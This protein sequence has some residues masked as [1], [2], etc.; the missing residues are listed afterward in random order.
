MKRSILLFLVLLCGSA[1]GQSLFESALTE[2]E[3]ST[4]LPVEINGFIRGMTYAGQ[5]TEKQE[6]DLKAALAELDLQFRVRKGDW[7]QG[8]AQFRMRRGSELGE[9][10]SEIELREAYA[11]FYLGALDLRIGHQIVVWGRAD[12][13]NPTNNI[14]PQNMLRRSPDED[15]RRQGNTMLRAFY[16]ANPF[17]LECI[18]TPV[19]ASST[20][21]LGLIPLPEA[22]VLTDT[23]T[24]PSLL[25]EGN[26]A[27]KLHL[28]TAKFDGSLSLFNGYAPLPGLAAA[29]PSDGS[30]VH[31]TPTPYRTR[32]LGADLQTTWG[33]TG[34]R[35]EV[36]WKTPHADAGVF[37]PTPEEEIH[38]VLG[39][40]RSWGNFNLILQYEF[41]H[42]PHWSTP[43]L[44]AVYPL[45][46]LGFLFIEK[47]RMLSGQLE[48]TQHGLIAR[49]SWT[50]C[51]ETLSLEMLTLYRLTTEE[52]MLAPRLR[53]DLADALTLT[54][55]ADL[56]GGPEA[57]LFGS[58]Q[59]AFSAG[60]IALKTAF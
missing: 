10:V 2:T 5:S 3:E 27:V 45:D 30:A 4:A 42:V 56:Y 43:V 15:D 7:G 14:T 16:A 31:V 21:P 17:R 20:L 35:G 37:T 51:H 19:Y 39:L 9:T 40:D 38:A 28:E 1:A 36:A 29:L 60:F 57:T 46:P 32:I 41:K 58:T 8:F 6:A 22:V 18:W 55:G 49:P 24:P 53:Y 59:D 12:G 25:K 54:L 33:P 11:A 44:P 50:L 48:K 52:W 23:W 47:N 13:I 34:L 26:I